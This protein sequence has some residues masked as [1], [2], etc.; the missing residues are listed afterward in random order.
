[1]EIELGILRL[2]LRDPEQGSVLRRWLDSG[3][4][5]G[6]AG[7]ILSLD[8]GVAHRSARLHV[9]ATRPDRDAVIAAT[10]LEHGLS[11]ATRNLADFERTGVKLVNPWAQ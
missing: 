3:V 5:V 10:A 7:R 9:P 2:E 1:M 8:L 11:V 6:F 4:L